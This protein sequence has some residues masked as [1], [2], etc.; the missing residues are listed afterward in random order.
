MVPIVLGE[1]LLRWS[2]LTRAEKIETCRML[3]MLGL[4][5]GEIRSFVPV[6]KGTLAG[7]C[8]GT[9]ISQEVAAEISARSR[10]QGQPSRKS[11]GKQ[12]RSRN[13]ERLASIRHRAQTEAS[14]LAG[15]P[16]WTAGLA[17]YWAEGSKYAEMRFANSDPGMINLF[18]AWVEEFIGTR[19]AEVTIVLHLHDGADEEEAISH[20]SN[21]TGVPTT[22]F[23]KT[24]WK[25]AG[26]GHRKRKLRF[27][28]AQAR[29][30]RSGD[31]LQ[32]V[33]GWI[34][35]F[36]N[37]LGLHPLDSSAGRWRNGSATDS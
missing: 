28:T 34:E 13:E 35:G 1:A 27:G 29:I 14:F 5:Y 9:P 11:V 6:P 33:L 17:A 36:K 32:R 18:L 22:N 24:Q 21:A 25:R 37:Q 12:L 15:S 2:A 30:P 20:W 31:T 3:R 10:T 8:K 19:R 4:S 23:R 26:G 16:R 7:W